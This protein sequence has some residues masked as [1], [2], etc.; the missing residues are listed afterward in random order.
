MILIMVIILLPVQGY[1]LE[2]DLWRTGETKEKVV[3]KAKKNKIELNTHKVSRSD[4]DVIANEI[5]YSDV[6]FQEEAQVSLVFTQ[7]TNMLYGIIIDWRDI[8]I[9]A[10]GEALYERIANTL[11]EK[12]IQDEEVAGKG[13]IRNNKEIFKDCTT[14]ITKY[15]GGISSTL[16]RCN[17]KRFMSVRYID[18]K[19]EQQNAFE[20]KKT[21]RKR[22]SDSGKF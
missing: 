7:K 5:H 3:A 20:G 8:A 12:Y 9:T 6:L 14:T 2:F 10:R 19:L 4:G 15:K 17:E 18:S 22:D 21:V 16:F 1:A 13:M 11:G